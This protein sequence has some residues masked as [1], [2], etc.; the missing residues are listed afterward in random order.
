MA[1][2]LDMAISL[3]VYSIGHSLGFFHAPL[4]KIS[5][6]FVGVNVPFGDFFPF[7][8]LVLGTTWLFRLITVLYFG[9]SF[10]QMLLGIKSNGS[11]EQNRFKGTLRT[12]AEIPSI[13]LFP[14]LDLGLLVGR[15]S[16]KEFISGSRLSA[17]SGVLFRGMVFV[18]C[19][20]ILVSM[21]SFWEI[22]FTPN[23]KTNF[24]LLGPRPKMDSKIKTK[25]YVS[26]NWGFETNSYLNESKFILIPSYQI[27]KRGNK[28]RFI[29]ELVIYDLKGKQ[30]GLMRPEKYIPLMELLAQVKKYNPL[31]TIFYP[32]MAK[33]LALGKKYNKVDFAFKAENYLGFS[34]G[35]QEEIVLYIQNAFEIYPRRPL[36]YVLSNGPFFRS[37]LTFRKEILNHFGIWVDSVKM[38]RFGNMTFLGG[39]APREK[40]IFGQK[41]FY[42]SYIPLGTGN[43]QIIHFNWP[44][45]PGF[46][47]DFLKSF[48]SFAKWYPDFENVFS[49]PEEITDF[50]ALTILD[51]YVDDHA[52]LS[53]RELLQ[54]YM[55]KYFSNLTKEALLLE[56]HLYQD[57]LLEAMERLVYVA[58]LKN[59]L[60]K[61]FFAP[62]FLNQLKGLK[63]SLVENNLAAN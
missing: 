28:N 15:R 22:P 13:L 47:K 59:N 42:E 61:E 16:F 26:S 62:V 10:S 27:K 63:Y 48:F 18:P 54:N 2:L 29:P 34:R 46:K 53:Q 3:N 1:F 50:S 56:D 12:L 39:S 49:F 21:A 11:F 41:G 55:I 40:N 43:G 37:S 35:L 8:L 57:V 51:F 14:L 30:V 23:I 6:F 5:K 38:K 4:E 33:E 44:N 58:R 52:T 31:F 25:K 36:N 17:K 9:V 24:G 60:E 19:F 20:I 32:Q 45:G 7:L